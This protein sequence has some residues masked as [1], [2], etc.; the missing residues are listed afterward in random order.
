MAIVFNGKD[1]TK[2]VYNGKE[3]ENVVYNGI[4]VLQAVT[5]AS[6]VAEESQI[7]ADPA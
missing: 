5:P 7:I 6:E 4:V 2:V 1:I 3:I